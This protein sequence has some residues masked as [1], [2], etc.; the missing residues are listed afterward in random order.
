MCACGR[1]S[2]PAV[3][4]VG[5][6]RWI[7]GVCS[8]QLWPGGSGERPPR[9]GGGKWLARGNG[10]LGRGTTAADAFFPWWSGGWGIVGETISCRLAPNWRLPPLLPL[11]GR[12]GGDVPH[13][14]MHTHT[15]PR[16]EM[17]IIIINN[18]ELPTSRR[19]CSSNAHTR[20]RLFFSPFFRIKYGETCLFNDLKMIPE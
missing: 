12:G 5:G 8:A 3:S 17:I 4:R 14:Y 7:A 19:R 10:R 11:A 2:M 15:R 18:T 9:G 13:R 1:Y 16:I 20:R 6:G